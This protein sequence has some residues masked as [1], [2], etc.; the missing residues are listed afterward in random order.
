VVQPEML[1]RFQEWTAASFMSR[2]GAERQHIVGGGVP[3][4]SCSV[5]SEVEAVASFM[6]ER[7]VGEVLQ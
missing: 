7:Y 6:A 3:A 2:D 4:S 1:W 5:R